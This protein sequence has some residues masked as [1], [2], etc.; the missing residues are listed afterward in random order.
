MQSGSI[1]GEVCATLCSASALY[2]LVDGHRACVC[3]CLRLRSSRRSQTH[4]GFSMKCGLDFYLATSVVRSWIGS[5]LQLIVK[6]SPP[7]TA[8]PDTDF[9]CVNV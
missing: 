9:Q 7:T 8:Q 1:Q 5:R 2:I 6:F 3:V 4:L